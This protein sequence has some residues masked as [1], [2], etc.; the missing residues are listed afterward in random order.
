MFNHC[1]TITEI[2]LISENLYNRNKAI[3][4]NLENFRFS[5]EKEKRKLFLSLLIAF[6]RM[7][8]Q[9]R[10]KIKKAISKNNAIKLGLLLK[11][12][13]KF[14]TFLEI[15]FFNNCNKNNFDFLDL[16]KF[17]SFLYA[18]YFEIEPEQLTKYQNFLSAEKS[19]LFSELIKLDILKIE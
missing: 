7:N 1:K 14:S 12:Y 10:R 15:D 19:K 17:D 18:I 6:F 3:L 2:L 11:N 16:K 5:G 13:P 9:F 4:E 8:E